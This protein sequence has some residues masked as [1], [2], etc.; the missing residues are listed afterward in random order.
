MAKGDD[1]HLPSR[2]SSAR[3]PYC[4]TKKY[5]QWRAVFWFDTVVLKV[6]TSIMNKIVLPVS[7]LYK[8][9]ILFSV[10][11]PPKHP[12]TACFHLVWRCPRLP[13]QDGNGK[14]HD[15]L[16]RGPIVPVLLFSI[17]DRTELR[18]WQTYAKT[19][20][21]VLDTR[22]FVLVLLVWVYFANF[23]KSRLIIC[24]YYVLEKM[25]HVPTRCTLNCN[26]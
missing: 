1:D 15:H 7:V 25:S 14:D 17:Y 23:R 20:H 24:R 13:S 3:L 8:C 10:C 5:E 9:N 12:T 2:G 16:P 21:E 19:V 18:Y 11:S 6:L 4:S 22:I 26:F